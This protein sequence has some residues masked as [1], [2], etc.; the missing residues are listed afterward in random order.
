M[1]RFLG[2][3]ENLQE[4]AKIW[5]NLRLGSVCPLIGLSPSALPDLRTLLGSP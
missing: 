5:E 4:S 1:L 3:G 2:N